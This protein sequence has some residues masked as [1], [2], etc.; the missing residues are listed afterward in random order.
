M[1]SNINIVD[2]PY[3]ILVRITK[4]L[5]LQDIQSLF[6]TNKFMRETYM[7]INEQISTKIQLNSNTEDINYFLGSNELRHIHINLMKTKISFENCLL[8]CLQQRKIERIDIYN[9]FGD[10]KIRMT[11][12][13]NSL[14]YLS[15]LN[16][17]LMEFS[18][19]SVDLAF[20]FIA[21]TINLKSL[22]Y[23]NG[24]LKKNSMYELIK[25]KHLKELCLRNTLVDDHKTFQRFL[26]S[27][28]NL[29]KLEIIYNKFTELPN[30]IK[31]SL[32]AFEGIKLLPTLTNIRL[33]GHQEF[34][35]ERMR[36]TLNYTRSYKFFSLQAGSIPAFF[37]AI[38]PL[39]ISHN[40]F[41]IDFSYKNDQ[42]PIT[43]HEEGYLRYS[44]SDSVDQTLTL[45]EHHS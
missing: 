38:L 45:Y 33:R 14:K 20:P 37:I 43:R 24:T 42:L 6:A 18:P 12:P 41:E 1:N 25:N 21:Q 17:E 26:F 3:E 5:S 13:Q 30:K 29:R 15:Y 28:C 35:I 11:I 7:N 10:E 22:K 2:L 23:S 31:I 40:I 32:I 8:Y 39:M 16:I 27:C 36:E 4:N 9:I 34:S 19:R 44:L